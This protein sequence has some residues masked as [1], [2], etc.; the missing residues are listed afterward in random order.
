M[1]IHVDNKGV[2]LAKFI[3]YLN[4]DKCAEVEARE[5]ED[6]C[7]DVKCSAE[8]TIGLECIRIKM[9]D[10]EY[11]KEMEARRARED[12]GEEDAMYDI[13]TGS[14]LFYSACPYLSVFEVIDP[15][16]NCE[17]QF[18]KLAQCEG[19]YYMAT[20]DIHGLK[21]SRLILREECSGKQLRGEFIQS[22]G[23]GLLVFLLFIGIPGGLG[24]LL[25]I[26]A[27]K[28]ND[29]ALSFTAELPG[30]ILIIIGGFLGWGGVHVIRTTITEYQFL[31]RNLVIRLDGKSKGS[32][33][34]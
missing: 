25:I 13:M 2:W 22:L 12:T 16:Q 30:F 23:W 8:D 7:F 10:A 14:N 9:E 29:Y 17:I 5:I 26:P 15:T 27:N 6:V 28:V 20:E 11:E 1:R 21:P 19:L 33:V 31:R 32:A 34:L 18:K 4:G 24:I 3:L